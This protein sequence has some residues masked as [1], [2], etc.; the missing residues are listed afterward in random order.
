MIFW[1]SRARK[2]RDALPAPMQDKVWAV[3]RQLE[4]EP[5]MGLRLRGRL[6]GNRAINIGRGHRMIYAVQDRGILI[7]TVRGRK[8]SY[9][10]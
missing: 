7:K 4:K 3:A 9:S 10:R 8:D 2:D 1:T 5:A 6:E